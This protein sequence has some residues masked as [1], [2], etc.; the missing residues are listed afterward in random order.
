[1]TVNTSCA[2]SAALLGVEGLSPSPLPRSRSEKPSS[3]GPDG[4]ATALAD[5]AGAELRLGAV[6]VGGGRGGSPFM[7][8]SSSS[9]SMLF[10]S[11]RPNNMI[12]VI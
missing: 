10:N 3:S 5:G 4:C 7:M 8:R 12:F 1:M 6:E 11:A 9:M 2:A